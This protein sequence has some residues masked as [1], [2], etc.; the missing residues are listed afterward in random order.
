LKAVI[1]ILPRE[2]IT[3]WSLGQ[4]VSSRNFVLAPESN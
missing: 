1:I 3:V 4:Y 2:V